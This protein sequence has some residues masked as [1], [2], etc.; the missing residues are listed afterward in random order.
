MTALSGVRVVDASEGVAGGYCTKL[1]AGLGAGVIKVERPGIGDTLRRT[2]PFL[3][4]IPHAETSALHLHLNAAKRSVTLDIT[5]ASGAALLLRLLARAD[6]FITR[7]AAPLP[8]SLSVAALCERFPELIVTSMTPFGFT[9]P[10]AG[11]RATDIVAHAM[12]GYLAMTGDPDR[13]P[14]KPYGHQAE[15]QAGLHAALGVVAGLTSRERC[16]AGGQH[17]DVAMTEAASFLIGGALARSFMF[18]RESKRNG[19][20]PVGLP[21]EYLYPSTIRPC[22]SGHVYVHRH[23]RF[24]DLVAALM[25][26]P[27]LAAPDVLAEPLGHADETDALIDRWLASRD[28]WRAVEEAQE[29]RVPF[30]EVLDPGEVVEDRLGQHTARDCFVDVEQPA[31]GTVRMPGAPVVMPATPWTMRPAPLLG[32]HNEEVFAVELGLS[33][34]GLARLSAAGVV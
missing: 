21:P 20:R 27:R 28:K 5:A 30:T 32:E 1:L 10:R 26:E 18:G 17:V 8:V 11:W 7:D 23:N 4:D 22:A 31:A 3:H 12:G 14:V 19:S 24:P 15:Y 25:H 2:G 6:V 34:R 29:L 13:E 16:G 33:R 9:G